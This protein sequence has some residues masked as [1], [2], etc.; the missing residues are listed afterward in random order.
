[1]WGFLGVIGFILST[2]AITSDYSM[3]VLSSH[4]KNYSFTPPEEM[5]D[6]WEEII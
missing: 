3:I 6:R 5:D 1:M 2:W 4:S